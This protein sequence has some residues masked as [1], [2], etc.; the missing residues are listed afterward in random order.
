[1]TYQ[2][3]SVQ[4]WEDILHGM[5]TLSAALYEGDDQHLFDLVDAKTF[6]DFTEPLTDYVPKEIRDHWLHL[7]NQIKMAILYTALYC[8]RYAIA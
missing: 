3:M 2:K 1:M 6:P 5:V 8:S 4:A 7:D